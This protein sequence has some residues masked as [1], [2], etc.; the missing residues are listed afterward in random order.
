MS[1]CLVSSTS[2]SVSHSAAAVLPSFSR[3]V[4]SLVPPALETTLEP[5]SPMAALELAFPAAVRKLD[6]SV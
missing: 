5:T 2:A 4:S 6:G 1:F 3:G